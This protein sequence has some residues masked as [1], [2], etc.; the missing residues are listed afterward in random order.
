MTLTIHTQED[1]QRQLAMTVEVPEDRVKKAMQEKARQLS[2]Q[3][4]LPGFR[5]G[6]VPYPI[7]VKYLG[8]EAIRSEAVE[9]MVQELYKEAITQAEIEPFAPGQ[10]DNMEL[11]PL[12]LKFTVPLEPVVDLGDYRELHKELE[13]VTVT[14]EAVQ[15]AL[16]RV[17]KRHQIVEPVER[18]AQAGDVVTLKGA[19][20]LVVE[21]SEEPGDSFFTE[22][23]IDFVLEADE[24]Y[25]GQPFIDAILGMSVDETKEFTIRLPEDFLDDGEAEAEEGEE[26][27]TETEA[28]T[29]PES[30][31]ATQEPSHGHFTITLLE[32]KNRILPE[33]NDDLAKEEGEYETLDELAAALRDDLQKSA[34]EVAKNQMIDEMMDDLLA[35]ATIN[36]PPAA[37]ESELDGMVED[38]KSRVTRSGWQWEDYLKLQGETEKS[39]RDTWREGA[40]RQ[41]RRSLVLRQFVTNEKLRIRAQE[42][43][44]VFEKRYGDLD[45]SLKESMR[46][47]FSES[48][49]GFSMLGGD[50]MMEKVADRVRA[51][52][53]GAA[54]DLDAIEEE[55]E[56][57]DWWEEEE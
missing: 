9:D 23:R 36:Y 54:P 29:T 53:S 46:R 57:E 24:L 52:R 37:I 3:I 51:I 39:L 41:V 42:L 55:E 34:E 28:E 44:D 15:E 43:D 47:F 8:E 38:L 35:Q 4:N 6:K 16:E 13:E 31:A 12:V 17:Q 14:D 40:V 50:L 2:R 19:G 45:D 27:A 25:Y 32:V 49:S 20:H 21:D 48:E 30:E 1:E 18:A 26:A 5:K 33:L 7:L 10:F 22:E 11:S 56:D